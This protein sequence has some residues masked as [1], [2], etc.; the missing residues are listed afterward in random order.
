MLLKFAIYFIDKYLILDFAI[1]DKSWDQT[2]NSKVN[3]LKEIKDGGN[4]LLS[5]CN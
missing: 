2:K 3:K 1:K 5:K 4:F